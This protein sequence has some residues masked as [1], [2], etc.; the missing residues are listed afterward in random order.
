MFQARQDAVKWAL[1]GGGNGVI[2][3]IGSYFQDH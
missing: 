2:F 3:T 1:Q